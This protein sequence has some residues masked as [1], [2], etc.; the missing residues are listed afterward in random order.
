MDVQPIVSDQRH[1]QYQ[2]SIRVAEIF[3]KFPLFRREPVNFEM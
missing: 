3:L 2:K 1:R